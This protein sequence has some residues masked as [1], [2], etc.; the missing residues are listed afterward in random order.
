MKT[1]NSITNL[2]NS[3]P[4]VDKQKKLRKYRQIIDLKN[5][6]VLKWLD[7]KDNFVYR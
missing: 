6:L 1:L 5:K 3:K 7:L 2:W 4:F